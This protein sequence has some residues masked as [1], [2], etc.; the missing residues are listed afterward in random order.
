MGK[1]EWLQSRPRLA[2]VG[3]LI[4]PRDVELAA[5]DKT[6][7]AVAAASAKYA[8]N[9]AHVAA[10]TDVLYGAF[11]AASGNAEVKRPG[12]A[13]HW[14]SIKRAADQDVVNNIKCPDGASGAPHVVLP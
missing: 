7:E 11:K 8:F 3:Y 5:I 4:R 14:V 12:E 6:R 1:R 9:D 13:N 2:V 10:A